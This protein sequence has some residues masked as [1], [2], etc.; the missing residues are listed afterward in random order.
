MSEIVVKQPRDQRVLIWLGMLWLGLAAAILIAQLIRQ[1]QIQVVWQTESEFETAGYNIYRSESPD[2]E[3]ARINEVMIQ[4]VPDAF[5]GGEYLYED[6]AI[7]T[8]R[9]Y[10]YR[11]EEV[12]LDGSTT[13]YDA[14]P[15]E[16][17][18]GSFRRLE[19]WAI[20]I[21]PLSIL[22]GILLLNQGLRTKREYEF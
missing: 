18:S 8:G 12:E 6:A 9:T 11:L 17:I 5:A 16:P 21:V 13:F 4:S 3:F 1:P 22:V 14:D 20:V 19:W 10:Y 2:G 7:E 15:D